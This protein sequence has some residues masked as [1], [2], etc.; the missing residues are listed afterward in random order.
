LLMGAG[1]LIRHFFVSRHQAR[2]QG[3][4]PAWGALFLSAGLL[5]A[6]MVGLRPEGKADAKEPPPS[7]AQVQQIVANR[8]QVCHNASLNSKNV[9]LDTAEMIQQ[10]AAAIYQQAVVQ[11]TMPMNNATQI[12]PAERAALGRWFAAGA[13]G[14]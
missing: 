12:T 2:L 1:A 14:P 9:R 6:L 13:T 10:Q 4:R 3:R 5:A 8:C 11:Q 7:F